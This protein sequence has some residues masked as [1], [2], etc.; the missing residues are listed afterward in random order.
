MPNIIDDIIKTFKTYFQ[1]D[2]IGVHD[3]PHVE[4]VLH[5]ANMLFL[6]EKRRNPDQFSEKSEIIIG[7]AALLHDIDDYKVTGDYTESTNNANKVME[8]VNVP[9]DIQKAVKTIIKEVP[10]H[11]HTIP[12]TIEGKIVQDADRLDALGYIGIARVFAYGGYDHRL[13]Y[14]PNESPQPPEPSEYK[15]NSRSSFS[16]FNDKILKIKEKMNTKLG[17]I[18]A[19][20]KTQIVTDFMNGFLSEWNEGI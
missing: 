5:N 17:K 10:W 16:H 9:E 15:T 1:E 8:I 19:E 2:G 3:I 18:L 14:D 4:R 6:N 20:G 12:T 7:I 13:I 11:N